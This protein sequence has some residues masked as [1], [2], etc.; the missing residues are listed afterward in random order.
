MSFPTVLGADPYTRLFHRQ[1]LV[2]GIF[3][4]KWLPL[5]QAFLNSIYALGGTIQD[6]KLFMAVVGTLF[7]CVA[8]V[9]GY[10]RFGWLMAVLW[11]SL[12]SVDPDIMFVTVAPYQEILFYTLLL[13]I[14][15]RV[16]TLPSS[17]AWL[18]ILEL[19][20]L[21][22]LALLCRYEGLL[23]SIALAAGIAHNWYTRARLRSVIPYI[24]LVLT[25]IIGPGLGYL[26]FSGFSDDYH[27]S[28]GG[29]VNLARIRVN[30][31]AIL[32]LV[33]SVFFLKYLWLAGLGLLIH[34]KQR[35]LVTPDVL[36]MNLYMGLFI[37][38]YICVCPYIPPANRRYHVPVVIWLYFYT[39][40]TL[41]YMVPFVSARSLLK[42][43]SVYAVLVA[44]V[45]PHCYW[46][47]LRLRKD[48]THN[49][50]HHRG[51]A[52]VGTFVD[53]SIQGDQK[54]LVAWRRGNHYGHPS[55]ANMRLSS[56]LGGR[57]NRLCF[58]DAEVVNNLPRRVKFLCSQEC[59][60][61]LV[62]RGKRM[63]PHEQHLISIV[64]SRYRGR[65]R[66]V[67]L[68]HGVDFYTWPAS[69]SVERLVTGTDTP[70]D[71]SFLGI[72][73]L[74]VHGGEQEHVF[75]QDLR[76]FPGSWASEFQLFWQGEAVGRKLEV[77]FE[78]SQA[79]AFYLDVGLTQGKDYGIVAMRVDGSDWCRL[80]VWS[81]DIAARRMRSS[82]RLWSAGWH[83]L[84]IEIIGRNEESAGYF[85]GMSSIELKKAPDDRW[86][87][88]SKPSLSEAPENQPFGLG[89]PAWAPGFVRV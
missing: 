17:L 70:M 7:L 80:D 83:E 60:G 76:L 22:V 13:I 41:A 73:G 56:Y 74:T 51:N 33:F 23:L 3:G 55:R 44:L 26:V 47:W 85:F 61:L 36:V 50:L 78:V 35:K 5:L 54:V 79:G 46:E 31:N 12:L 45:A 39:S 21:V 63:R 69:D 43:L 67:Q 81:P 32:S 84:T 82:A 2:V 4:R 14:V 34:A 59:G 48:I 42:R 1:E 29:G 16:S 65:L 18:R 6:I 9:Y 68:L 10:R 53:R 25:F 57:T 75:V 58:S 66:K 19:L 77:L 72:E 49:L 38:T 11:C 87:E 62:K 89:R 52:E 20:A 88:A 24:L 71:V 86:R 40:V 15:W 28:L 30:A 37:L 64:R 8:F 27:S